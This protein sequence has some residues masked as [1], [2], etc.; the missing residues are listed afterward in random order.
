MEAPNVPQRQREIASNTVAPARR[1]SDRS[2]T[3]ARQRTQRDIESKRVI[4]QFNCDNAL[5]Q[6]EP[7]R[8]ITDNKIDGL[9]EL[10]S[11]VTVRCSDVYRSDLPATVVCIGTLADCYRYMDRARHERS[12]PIPSIAPNTLIYEPTQFQEG[13]CAIW[14]YLYVTFKRCA[15]R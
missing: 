4:V 7:Y 9:P 15:T 1:H 3:L 6:V 8:I 13:M 11:E 5:C 14:L 2:A 12:Y 10:N